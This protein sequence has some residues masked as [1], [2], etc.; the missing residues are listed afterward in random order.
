MR[1]RTAAADGGLPAAGRHRRGTAILEFAV[2]SGVLLAAF[3]GAFDFGY[4]LLQYNKLELAVSQGARYASIISYDSA[5]TTPSTGFLTAVRNMVL[6]GSPTTGT[7]PVLSGL[8]ASN[9]SVTVTFSNGVPSSME[10]SITGYTINALFG[11]Y[12]LSGKPQVT[13]PYQ[14][15]WAPV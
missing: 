3:S 15:V 13:F 9:V 14:G 10:V 7:A 11:T 6:Y 4:T 8:T 1:K 5:T 12:L 2:G